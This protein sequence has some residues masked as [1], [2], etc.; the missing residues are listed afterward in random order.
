MPRFRSIKPQHWFDQ[1]LRFRTLMLHQEARTCLEK[2]VHST[3]NLEI[4]SNALFHLGLLDAQLGHTQAAR[5]KFSHLGFR[6]SLP[7]EVFQQNH[8]REHADCGS[9]SF[10]KVQDNVL[11]EAWCSVL[12]KCFG[13]CGSF[14]KQFGAVCPETA[15]LPAFSAVVPLARPSAHAGLA[16]CLEALQAEVSR[17]Y[18]VV[19]H[20]SAAELW[21]HCRGPSDLDGHPLHF[22]LDPYP[23]HDRL[24]AVTTILYLSD[25]GAPTI[26][27]DEVCDGSSAETSALTFPKSGRA[28]HYESD[29]LHGVLPHLPGASRDPSFSNHRVTIVIAW[30]LDALLPRQSSRLIPQMMPETC[31]FESLDDLTLLEKATNSSPGKLEV[32]LGWAKLAAQLC[33]VVLP[34]DLRG[35]GADLYE[36]QRGFEGNFFLPDQRLPGTQWR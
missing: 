35:V 20:A 11:P 7:L 3:G 15:A 28:L 16:C 14:W 33:D 9:V 6:Y 25:G 24:S 13:F 22:D 36:R 8:V 18:P 1:G 2:V 29:R 12:R 23:P 27:L 34:E 21:W 26:V 5:I 32:T 31:W 10:A 17:H 30:W 4:R 19:A